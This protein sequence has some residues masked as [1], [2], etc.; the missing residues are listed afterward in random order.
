LSSYKVIIPFGKR[1]Y[2]INGKNDILRELIYLDDFFNVMK[3]NLKRP[4][5]Y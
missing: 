2:P 3:P 5:R 4:I 1:R